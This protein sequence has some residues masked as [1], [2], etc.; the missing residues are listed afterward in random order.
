[1]YMIIAACVSMIF[2]G[3]SFAGDK[4][5]SNTMF[6]DME[7]QYLEEAKDTMSDKNEL[8]HLED[9]DKHDNV[10]AGNWKNSE[11]F[12]YNTMFSDMELEYL[13]NPDLKPD[14]SVDWILL[15]IIGGIL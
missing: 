10:S 13:R 9:A 3:V 8:K 5:I 11:R 2:T 7:L 12:I 6:S 14:G 15:A 1:M 4:Y